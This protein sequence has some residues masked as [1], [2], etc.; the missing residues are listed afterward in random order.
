MRIGPPELGQ[1]ITHL[2]NVDGYAL[3]A[4]TIW[5]AWKRARNRHV[6]QRFELRFPVS[7]PNHELDNPVRSLK[8]SIEPNTYD[9]LYRQRNLSIGGM[10]QHLETSAPIR[11]PILA[12][13]ETHYCYAI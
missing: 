2:L 1:N 3:P 4:G 6:A 11:S 9:H 5:R 8:R 7:A 13:D 12:H 10:D